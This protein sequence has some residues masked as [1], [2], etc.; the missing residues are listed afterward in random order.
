MKILVNG[1]EAAV[2]SDL[3]FDYVIENRLFLGRDGYTLD[4]TFPLRECPENQDIFGHINRPDVS[5]ETIYFPCEI[6]DS[7]VC[8]SGLLLVTGISEAEVKCQFL[9]GRCE[10]T[11]VDP[12][13]DRF[14]NDLDLGRPAI[15]D[16]AAVTPDEAWVQTNK[17]VAL[18]WINENYPLVANNWVDFVKGTYRWHKDV[19]K[20]SWQPYLIEIAR[21]ICK[22]IGYNCDF[23]RWEQSE[24][25][26]LIICNSLPGSWEMPDYKYV[27]PKWT[28]SEFFEKLELL[29]MGEFN[30][31]HRIKN[32]SFEFSKTVIDSTP[33]VKIESVLDEFSGEISSDSEDSSCEYISAKRLAYKECSHS[34]WPYYSCDWI[35]DSVIPWRYDTID[36]LIEENKCRIEVTDQGDKQYL[37]GKEIPALYPVSNTKGQLL[38]AK[39]VDCYFVMRSVGT[40]KSKAYVT[41]FDTELGEIKVYKTVYFPRYVLLQVNVFGCGSPESDD[42][43]TQEIEFVPACIMDTWISDKDDKG[44]MMFLSFSGDGSEVQDYQEDEESKQIGVAKMIEA[45][46]GKEAVEYYD[47]IQ[48]AYWDGMVPDWGKMPF[49]VIDGEIITS[50]WR[51]IRIHFGGL[52]LTGTGRNIYKNIPQI[53]PKKKYKFSWLSPSIPNPRAIYHIR[54]KRYVCEKITAT[55]TADGMSQLLKGEFYPLADD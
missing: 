42:V 24:Y 14:I 51:S 2:R 28:V 41:S 39:D 32:V 33:A 1:M 20:L 16:A 44:L 50:D 11:A 52:R 19:K 3:S 6:S 46:N 8:L 12:F 55:F 48:V 47:C 26:Y 17:E 53:Q 21:R 4:I 43:E 36:Q 54:G 45:G 7:H 25:R 35:L 18:P 15:V 29:L 49:P 37:Y 40:I 10:H 34:L 22:A 13:E 30:F 38:Y 9:E 5:T 27:M 23:S 31:D